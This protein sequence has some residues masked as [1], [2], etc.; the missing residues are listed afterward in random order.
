VLPDLAAKLLL[1]A[2]QQS[3]QIKFKN[4]A[5]LEGWAVKEVMDQILLGHLQGSK[6]HL[7]VGPPGT[8]KTSA[9]IKIASYEI[10]KNRK[11]VALLT[12]DQGKVGAAEQM[13]IYAQI[14]NAPFGL[15]QKKKDWVYVTEKLKD[16]DYILCDFPGLSLK[17]DEE[18]R[19]FTQLLPHQALSYRTHLV[20]STMMKS[21]DV[22]PIVERYQEYRVS[23]LIFTNLDQ[24]SSFGLIYNVLESF[25]LPCLGLS[26]GSKVPEDFEYASKERLVDLILDISKDKMLWGKSQHDQS[27]KSM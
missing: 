8:G 12:A 27:S 15:I 21:R 7:F 24:C 14:L 17:T 4:R 22:L 6:V 19:V 2:Q 1:K 20:I 25:K 23:D 3:P 26:S 16:Y 10:L 18:N 11:K 9:M 13:R 5:F